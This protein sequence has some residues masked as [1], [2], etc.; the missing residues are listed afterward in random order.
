L[1]KTRLTE[2]SVRHLEVPT[3]GQLTHWDSSLANFGLRVSSKG[4]KTWIVMLGQDRRRI[5]IGRYP[6]IGIAVA[7]DQAKKLLAEAAL[8]KTSTPAISIEDLV[9]QFLKASGLRNKSGTTDEYQRLFKRH[10]LPTLAK[11]RVGDLRAHEVNKIIDRLLDTPA[12]ANHALTAIKALLNFALRRRYIE[13]SPCQG[14]PL[15]AK[16]NS[17]SR[18][19]S[20][21]EIAKVFPAASELGHP[22]GNI[23]KLCLLTGQR[24][25]EI[26]LLKWEYINTK[27][28]QITLPAMIVKNNREHSFPY[29]D[30]VA[31]VLAE[32]PQQDEYLFPTGKSYGSIFNGWG[33]Q[34]TKLD[35]LAPLPHWTPHDLRRT[36]ATQ[37]ASLAIPPHV[38][39]RLINHASGTI[40]GVAAIY[41]RYS[42][43]PEMR[44]A[45]ASYDAHLRTILTLAN[46]VPA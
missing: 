6:L 34:K 31:E 22:F 35:K 17:R 4:S 37:M 28:R 30:R 40:S 9:V 3:S 39:E 45:I 36:F 18:V 13:H 25:G 46:S 12:E 10:F 2:V 11:R 32:I 21:N 24:R 7:R 20:E 27:D 26:A 38:V 15:P 44:A 43:L 1:T 33:K 41:N 19:L 29:G 42:Y 14:M 16:R 8:G 5:S 23:I